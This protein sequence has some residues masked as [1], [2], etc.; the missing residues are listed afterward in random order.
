MPPLDRLESRG[1]EAVRPGT[2]VQTAAAIET[3]FI[4]ADVAVIPKGSSSENAIDVDATNDLYPR[5]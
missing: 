3:F 1:T 5:H 4:E 2:G